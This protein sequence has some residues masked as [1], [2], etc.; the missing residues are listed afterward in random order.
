M[1]GRPS[2]RRH[3]VGLHPSRTALRDRATPTP[4]PE[5]RDLLTLSTPRAR[6]RASSA[7]SP[8]TR[9][10][11]TTPS[12]PTR[13]TTR[14][15]PATPGHVFDVRFDPRTGRA[16]FRDVSLASPT[17]RSPTSPTTTAPAISTRPRT[18]GSCACPTRRATGAT[19]PTDCRW[20]RSPGSPSCPPAASCMPRRTG[21]RTYRLRLPPSHRH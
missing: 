6:R 18:T 21:A 16:R 15:H 5:R 11:P 12:C 19:P 4:R 10:T 17:S 3:D 14:R 2:D 8:S 20:P 7:A 1:A 9:G 13:A